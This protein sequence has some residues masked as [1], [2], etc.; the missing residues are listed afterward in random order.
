MYITT[1]QKKEDLKE[2]VHLSLSKLTRADLTLTLTLILSLR[3]DF[4]RAIYSRMSDVQY[5][6]HTRLLAPTIVV[7]ATTHIGF[8]SCYL[9]L[10]F[11]LPK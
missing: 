2:D 8:E 4:E 10:K 3:S 5:S 7:V 11:I 1:L 6:S 9:V